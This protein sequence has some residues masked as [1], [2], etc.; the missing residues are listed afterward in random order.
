[1]TRMTIK[2]APRRYFLSTCWQ[3]GPAWTILF[4]GQKMIAYQAY[5]TLESWWHSYCR[6][7]STCWKWNS[8]SRLWSG[9]KIPKKQISDK[10]WHFWF[11][12]T[13]CSLSPIWTGIQMPTCR[14]ITASWKPW[15]FLSTSTN[16]LNYPSARIF[17]STWYG[18]FCSQAPLSSTTQFQNFRLAE[19]FCFF[20]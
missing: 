5:F 4:S 3:S 2:H 7:R 9:K 1:M 13:F 10:L 8:M 16:F 17:E 15:S 19:D 18:S 20:F 12:S 6:L 11:Y 14:K